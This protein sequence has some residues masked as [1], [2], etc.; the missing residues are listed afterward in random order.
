[1]ATM[2]MIQH[3]GGKPANFLD[4]GGGVNED[5]VFKAFQIIKSVEQVYP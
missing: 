2:D 5:Q 4:L 3:C 1:M